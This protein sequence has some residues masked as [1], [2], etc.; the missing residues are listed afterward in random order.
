MIVEGV[1]ELHGAEHAVIPDRIE[2]APS[3]SPAQSAERDH[4]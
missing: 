2:A 1:K 3:S 4:D